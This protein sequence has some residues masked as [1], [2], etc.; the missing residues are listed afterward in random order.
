MRDFIL[1]LLNN[2]TQL[3]LMVLF[4]SALPILRWFAAILLALVTL[5]PV[6]LLI[7]M[8]K[9][10]A[11]PAV[12]Q[13]VSV[14]LLFGLS[15]V[16]RSTGSWLLLLQ[17]LTVLG[18]VVVALVHGFNPHVASMWQASLKPTLVTLKSL[19]A[20]LSS[21]LDDQDMP[22]L[23]DRIAQVA[24]G[25][26]VMLVSAAS[27]L[28]VVFGRYLQASLFNPGG[29]KKELYHIHLT[30]FYASVLLG[31]I[32]VGMLFG[33]PWLLDCLGVALLPFIAAGLS[34]LHYLTARSS[35]QS[36]WL[37]FCYVALLLFPPEVLA[38]LIGASFI[39]AWWNLR[40]RYVL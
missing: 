4:L 37:V 33:P 18:L 9:I 5:V 8:G 32:L 39:D 35:R 30:P 22:Q 28:N 34:L 31:V 29:L 40:Q 6:L 38:V 25:L 10:G 36:L 7:V 21:T 23:L 3:L 11:I 15:W 1:R 12:G 26:Q 19:P 16:L 14:L 13:V 2:R 20:V 27:L 17:L 24:T